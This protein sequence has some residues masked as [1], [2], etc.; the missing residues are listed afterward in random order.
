VIGFSSEQRAR[1]KVQGRWLHARH[2]ERKWRLVGSVGREVA[3]G[4][5][6]VEHAG[7]ASG[8]RLEALDMG[9]CCMC[10]AWK[11]GG[12]WQRSV[13]TALGGGPNSAH[14]V[15][16]SNYSNFAQILKYKMKTILKSKNIET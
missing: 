15:V 2:V 10:G 12:R 4:H 16:F 7:P 3:G 1:G 13:V 8:R 14:S 11:S 6:A 9:G 5:A